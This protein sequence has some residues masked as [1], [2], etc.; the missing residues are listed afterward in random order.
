MVASIAAEPVV[1]TPYPPA[2]VGWT[3]VFVL[4]LLYCLAMVDR[5]VISL[6][7][8]DLKSE[9]GVSDFQIS[10]LQG[11]AF[12]V[13]FTVLGVPLGL[14]ADR[15]P[16]R[17]VICFGV[18]VWALAATACGLARTY[19]QLLIARTFVGAGEA[20]LAPAAYAMLSDLFPKRRLTTALSIF[21]IGAV[22]GSELSIA[23]SGLILGAARGG[24]D[25]PV[26]GH[27][28]A[29][30]VAFLATGAPGLLLA[31]SVFLIPEPVRRSDKL[32]HTGWGHVLRF[33]ASRGG[34][35]IA[36]LVGFAC[37]IG[38]AYARLSW[39]PTFLVRHFGWPVAK[40]GVTLGAFGVVTGTIAFLI[41]GP[42]V[43]RLFHRGMRD[44][45]FKFYTVGAVVLFLCGGAAFLAPN[46]PLFFLML[47]GTALFLNMSAV[48]ASA[49][50]LVTPPEMRG[51]VSAI[52]LAVIS[53]FGM[54]V[55]PS[56][57]GF[58]TD[59]VFHDPA[60]VNW[61]LTATFAILS[62]IALLAFWLGQ[63]PMRRAVAAREAID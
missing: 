16:R 5:Q 61:S 57:V 21:S 23:I 46:V 25:L 24:V 30:R 54:T 27:A 59:K 14:A 26:L 49:I 11:F 19:P 22:I 2:R 15:L 60:K 38:L 35:F 4:L 37:I 56:M 52:Y 44:A 1:E 13:L 7:V 6:M 47:V 10:L 9:L 50:Q 43:D 42:L 12:A 41:T 48:G 17:K 58:F 40:V 29:W 8:G 63:G 28:A 36:Q 20:A 53:L 31:F 32:G 34:F 62:P 45:H 3:A 33:M 39:T 55:G 18:L 51:R